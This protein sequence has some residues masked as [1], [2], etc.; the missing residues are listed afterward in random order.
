MLDKSIM[1]F[2]VGK[3]LS[4]LFEFIVEG[5]LVQED[6]II[7]CPPV[8]AIF[9]LLDRGGDFPKVGVP[10]QYHVNG[11]GLPSVRVCVISGHGTGWNH[12]VSN[13][14]VVLLHIVQTS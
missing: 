3:S 11:V 5:L 2:G 14:R 6:V 12:E 1:T 13:T 7:V 9:M 10:C 8:E 4:V